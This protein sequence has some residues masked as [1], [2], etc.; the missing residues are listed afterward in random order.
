[1]YTPITKAGKLATAI[2]RKFNVV[3]PKLSGIPKPPRRK[4][5]EVA[6][7]NGDAMD[8]SNNP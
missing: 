2:L 6:D 3:S 1:M 4:N 8:E 5:K 7:G